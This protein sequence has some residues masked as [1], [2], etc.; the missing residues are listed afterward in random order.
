MPAT[1]I[2]LHRANGPDVTFMMSQ[3]FSP[4]TCVQLSVD[5]SMMKQTNPEIPE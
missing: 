3:P 4:Q 1:Q 2:S 5:I